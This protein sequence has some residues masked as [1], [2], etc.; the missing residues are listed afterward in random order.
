MPPEDGPLRAET[1]RSVTVQRKW[2]GALVGFLC[3][4]KKDFELVILNV[5][6]RFVSCIK[7]QK[8]SLFLQQKSKTAKVG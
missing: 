6:F 8:H 7:L 3:K 4:K 5:S 2:C 1:R